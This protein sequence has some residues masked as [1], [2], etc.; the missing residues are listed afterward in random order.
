MTVWLVPRDKGTHGRG[1]AK[2]FPLTGA[3]IAYD[4]RD[5]P[6]IRGR[7]LSGRARS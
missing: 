3:V 5:R 2:P 4:A 7:S 6:Q 1:W